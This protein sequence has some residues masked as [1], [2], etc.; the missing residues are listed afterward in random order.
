[1]FWFSAILF[2]SIIQSPWIGGFAGVGGEVE[3]NVVDKL[4]EGDEGKIKEDDVVVE[5]GEITGEYEIEED[6]VEVEQLENIIPTI[7]VNEINSS[8]TRF[9]INPICSNIFN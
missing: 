5:S 2:P 8:L 4:G 3:V 7:I 1:M 6:V 9:I